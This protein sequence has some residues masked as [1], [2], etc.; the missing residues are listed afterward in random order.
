MPLGYHNYTVTIRCADCRDHIQTEVTRK[1]GSNTVS[2]AITRL[3]A[4]ARKAGWVNTDDWRCPK[5]AT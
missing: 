3:S 1:A 5:H 2:A 4:Q